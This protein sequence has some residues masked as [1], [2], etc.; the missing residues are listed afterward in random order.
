MMDYDGKFGALHL[1]IRN[2]HYFEKLIW[3]KVRQKCIAPCVKKS[4]LGFPPHRS[5]GVHQKDLD[6]VLTDCLLLFESC[7]R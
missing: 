1:E 2:L 7:G 4:E 6:I 5:F 3:R